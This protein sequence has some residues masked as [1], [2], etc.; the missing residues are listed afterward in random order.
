M[1]DTEVFGPSVS[2]CYA[3]ISMSVLTLHQRWNDGWKIETDGQTGWFLM[4]FSGGLNAVKPGV[5]L[6]FGLKMSVFSG[7]VVVRTMSGS[8]WTSK[9]FEFKNTAKVIWCAKSRFSKNTA[10]IQTGHVNTANSIRPSPNL[11]HIWS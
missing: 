6:A 1:V 9:R 8:Q 4:E 2:A 3:A 5:K 7:E 11:V 10:P